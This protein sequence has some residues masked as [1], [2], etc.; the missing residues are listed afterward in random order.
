MPPPPPPSVVCSDNRTQWCCLMLSE[1]FC[2]EFVLKAFKTEHTAFSCR[3]LKCN[4][5]ILNCPKATDC[6]AF[7]WDHQ[8]WF[9]ASTKIR[10]LCPC[11]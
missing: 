4:I 5:Y 11:V 7:R 8:P 2:V 1:F 9:N 6:D 10:E 3:T